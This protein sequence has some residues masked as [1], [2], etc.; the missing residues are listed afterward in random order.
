VQLRFFRCLWKRHEPQAIQCAAF[1][2][3]SVDE[4]GRYAFPAADER[5]LE[6]LRKPGTVW[7]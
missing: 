2:W 1:R 6:I 4:L 5:L 3:I 7:S